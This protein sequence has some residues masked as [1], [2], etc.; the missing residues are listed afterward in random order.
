MQSQLLP[1]YLDLFAA[2]LLYVILNP[3]EN[4]VFNMG[5]LRNS[6]LAF[7]FLKPPDVVI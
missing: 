6:D 1:F 2:V 3:L 5:V 4:F 7:V